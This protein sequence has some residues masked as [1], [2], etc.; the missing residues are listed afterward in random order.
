MNLKDINREYLLP[1]SRRVSRLNVYVINFGRSLL[2]VLLSEI[3]KNVS[4]SSS[5]VLR[6]RL[7]PVRVDFVAQSIGRVV[8]VWEA[9]IQREGWV[10]H[11]LGSTRH[12]RVAVRIGVGVAKEFV[13]SFL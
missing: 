9:N 8:S 13:F 10:T 3:D 11:K 2:H 1:F 4:S 5:S 12:D 7:T 6:R